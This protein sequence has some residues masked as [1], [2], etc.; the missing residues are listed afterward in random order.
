MQIE[1]EKKFFQD[2]FIDQVTLSRANL[3]ILP[4]EMFESQV[5]Q[6]AP[7][8]K[9]HTLPTEKLHR[10]SRTDGA[11]GFM[12]ADSPFKIQRAFVFNVYLSKPW[13]IQSEFTLMFL[14]ST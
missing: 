13:K 2:A 1:R 12:D 14:Y 7:L 10:N 9:I 8:A 6:R 11:K 4:L 3:V 5:N